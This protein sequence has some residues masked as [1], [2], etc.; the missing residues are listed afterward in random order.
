MYCPYC[1]KE[2][3]NTVKFCVSCG[4][5][6][7]DTGTGGRA[8]RSDGKNG[9][10]MPES[11]RSVHNH[12]TNGSFTKHDKEAVRPSGMSGMGGAASMKKKRSKKVFVIVALLLIVLLALGAFFGKGVWKSHQWKEYYDLGSQYLTENNY[13][14]AVVAFTNAIEVDEKKPEAY[15]GRGDAYA[16]SA[17]KAVE[18]GKLEEASELYAKAAEDYKEAVKLNDADA[19][20]KLENIG[21]NTEA[22]NSL[23]ADITIVRDDRSVKDGT[24]KL[25]AKWYYDKAVLEETTDAMKQIN[26]LIQKECNEYFEAD[27]DFKEDILMSPPQLD[28]EWYSNYS[29]AEV[30]TNREGILSIKREQFFFMGGVAN[31]NY[32]GL[33]Y[34]L[35][36]GEELNLQDVFSMGGDQICDYLKKQTIEYIN[37]NPEEGWWDDNIQDAEQIVKEYSISEFE[38]YIEDNN[39]YLCYPTYELGPGA[40]GPVI[41]ECPIPEGND[42][43]EDRNANTDRSAETNKNETAVS[44]IGKT[45]S[46]VWETYGTSYEV[47]VVEG[48]REVYYEDIGVGFAFAISDANVSFTGNEK[49]VW[50]DVFKDTD[51]GFNIRGCITYEQI[52]E[53][54][55]GIIYI[56]EPEYS[57]DDMECEYYYSLSFKYKGMQFIYT[58]DKDPKLPAGVLQ[59][60]QS[61]LW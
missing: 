5:S 38:F 58:W 55:G 9:S 15:V 17:E 1:G 11:A 45:L 28:G 2:N 33:N 54:M 25:L 20:D 14:E 56:E 27:D 39:V 42:D 3:E 21:E 13:E 35:I 8:E 6:L 24:G 16:G 34:N 44:Y 53:S 57:Y 7:V 49:I 30:T 51:V 37:D 36:S 59:V 18:A 31:V 43:V 22:L 19:K 46:D 40:M 41:I 26:N 50:I 32:Y 48:G 60:M 10:F 12:R 52:R 4:K 29:E 61:E 47:Y 23:S